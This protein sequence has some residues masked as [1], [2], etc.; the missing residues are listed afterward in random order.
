MPRSSTS[1]PTRRSSDLELL[2]PLR[3]TEKTRKVLDPAGAEEPKPEG[4]GGTGGAK[5][6]SAPRQKGHGRNGPGAYQGARKVSVAHPT[7]SEEHTSELQ[8]HSDLVCP[9][10]PPLSLHDALPI[11]SC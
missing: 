6:A 1:I 9:D 3:T 10:R 4:Q 2:T 7:R 8:S 5:A 11:S